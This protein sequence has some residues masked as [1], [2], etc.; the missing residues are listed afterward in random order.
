MMSTHLLAALQKPSQETG[1]PAEPLSGRRPLAGRDD[2]L[3]PAEVTRVSAGSV[4]VKLPSGGTVPAQMALAVPYKSVVGDVLLVIGKGDD[5]YVIGVLRGKGQTRL[6]L[7]GDVDLHAMDGTLSLSADKG[8]RISGPEVGIETRRLGVV[9]GALVEHLTSAVRRVT[10]LL[11]VQAGDAHTVA[12]GTILQQS[13]SA[14]ILTEET[15]AVN[16]RQV[17]L[18]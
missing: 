5:H 13:K 16:G 1:D 4:E 14:S 12:Q 9:A 7:Q 17:H 8:V 2:Y 18:G 11:S 3:G 15:V 10:G 6:T